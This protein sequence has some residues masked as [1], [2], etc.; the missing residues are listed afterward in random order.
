MHMAQIIKTQI[1]DSQKIT[2]Y[3][4][5]DSNESKKCR[6]RFGMNAQDKWC[7]HC[8][9]KKKC[10]YTTGDDEERSSSHQRASDS[11]EHILHLFIR[12]LLPIFNHC[13]LKGEI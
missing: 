8:V 7:K 5:A 4:V 10:L 12:K 6:A 1:V 11:G 13:R 2:V 3:S 9:R